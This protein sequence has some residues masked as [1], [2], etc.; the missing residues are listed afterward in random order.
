LCDLADEFEARG[1]QYAMDGKSKLDVQ[2]D[3]LRSKM[4]KSV[5]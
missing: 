3:V 2:I 5:A 4:G 1:T